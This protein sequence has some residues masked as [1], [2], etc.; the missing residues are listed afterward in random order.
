MSDAIGTPRA[1]MPRHTR[2]TSAHSETKITR[3]CATCE[4]GAVALGA[5]ARR[6]AKIV[7]TVIHSS[8]ITR[9]R[10]LATGANGSSGETAVVTSEGSW[11][12]AS[13]PW[14]AT[15]ALAIGHAATP[16]A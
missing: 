3:Y 16:R 15:A 8:T 4:C 14:F 10:S 13:P 11:V 2:Y 5:C 7:T 12:I 6:A 1:R 9:W